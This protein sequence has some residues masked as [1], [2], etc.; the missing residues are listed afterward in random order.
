[1]CQLKCPVI[2]GQGNIQ[3]SEVADAMLDAVVEVVGKKSQN[4]LKLVRMVIFQPA[5]LTD[6]HTSMLKK[7]GTDAQEKEGFFQNVLCMI[8]FIFY[9]LIYSTSFMENKVRFTIVLKINISW[10]LNL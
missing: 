8:Y 7:E 6:F 10:Y 1:M 2:Q 9:T 3:P 4:S 5:M